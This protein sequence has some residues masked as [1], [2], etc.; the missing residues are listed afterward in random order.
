MRLTPPSDD[1]S[2]AVWF[3]VVGVDGADKGGISQVSCLGADEHLV[4]ERCG[5]QMVNFEV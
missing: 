4:P 3:D 1:L 2:L 5:C